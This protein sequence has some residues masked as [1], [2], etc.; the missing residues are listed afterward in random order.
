[1]KNKG[2]QTSKLHDTLNS[3]F[4]EEGSYNYVKKLEVYHNND[5]IFGLFPFYND[6]KLD[7]KVLESSFYN[8]FKANHEFTVM[9]SNV[10]KGSIT[11]H[12]SIE[13]K[14]GE[15]ITD[16]RGYYDEENKRI[17]SLKIVTNLSKYSLG[18]ISTLN[19][20]KNLFY[21]HKDDFFI[22]GFKTAYMTD[23]AQCYLSYIGVYYES[24]QNYQEKY[25]SKQQESKILKFIYAFNKKADKLIYSVSRFIFI[26]FLVFFPFIY[27]YSR[28]QNI[29]GG[30]VKI[31][32]PRDKD[33][34]LNNTQI[35]TDEYG[36]VHIK[37]ENMMDAMFSLGF[38]QS[39]DRLFQ[40]DFLR[41]VA[42]GRLSEMMGEG[43][44]KVDIMMRKMGLYKMTEM[45]D[46]FFQGTKAFKYVNKYVQGINYF[47]KNFKLPVEYAMMRHGFD[48]FTSFDVV[49][50]SNFMTFTLTEDWYA[51]IVYKY[52]E[53]SIGK[54]FADI[55]LSIK[56]FEV[57]FGDATIINDEELIDLGLSIKEKASAKFIDD[58]DE[59]TILELK[60]KNEEAKQTKE[61][62]EIK[63]QDK[64]NELIKEKQKDVKSDKTPEITKENKS[65]KTND[66]K[67]KEP[68][69]S[70]VPDINTNTT[71]TNSTN[72]NTEN[73]EVVNDTIKNKTK[74]NNTLSREIKEITKS[75]I[76]KVKESSIEL[77]KDIINRN[78]ENNI[79]SKVENSLNKD[80]SEKKPKE[81]KIKSKE[82]DL[83]S[84]KSS[85]TIGID[86]IPTN[87]GAS[88]NWVISGKHTKNG[89]AILA[90]DPHL[91]NS[92]PALSYAAKI[93]LPD[94]IISGVAMP[95][96][97]MFMS[98]ST[99][100]LSWGVT[101]ENNDIS[102]LCEEIIEDD[103]Y[104]FND[105][106]FPLVRTDETILIKG[107]EEENL[108]VLW[109]K[110]GPVIDELIAEINPLKMNYKSNSQ[111]SFRIAWYL[112]TDF[113]LDI[114]FSL[115]RAK[116]VKELQRS[117]SGT[118][119][120]FL[121]FVWANVKGDIGYF[122]LG[123]LPIK[124]PLSSNLT[125][126]SFCKGWKA[127]DDYKEILN[128][129]DHP[130]IINP[131]KGYM[132]TANNRMT[133][134]NYIHEYTG[135]HLFARA[136]RIKQMIEKIISNKDKE[137]AK[138]SV[139]DNI[140][141]LADVKDV[142][143]EFLVPKLI[144]IYERNKKKEYEEFRKH[145]SQMQEYQQIA[146]SNPDF[147]IPESK[148]IPPE[149]IVYLEHLR[150][151]NYTMEYDSHVAT[152]YTVLE[153]HIGIELLGGLDLIDAQGVLSHRVFWNFIYSLIEKI[154]DGKNIDLKA[155]SYLSGSKNCEKYLVKVM[156]K[157]GDYIVDEA[158]S[159]G[160]V[161][162]YGDL[163]PQV[164]P[165]LVFDKI[166]I[167]RNFFSKRQ[168]S[169]GNRNTVKVSVN[170]YNNP[171]GKFSSVHSP[172]SQF[173]VDM[174]TPN[175]PYINIMTGNSGNIFSKYYINRI[176]SIDKADLIVYRNYEFPEGAE[177]D[178]LHLIK[179]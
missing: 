10:I 12:I 5:G 7:K 20:T 28:S 107:R 82:T 75:T 72:S 43:A 120:P 116:H 78:T 164:Y 32:S 91:H 36:F 131:K 95:G 79:A 90:N 73:Q 174:K 153:Y 151:W 22:P 57:P 35:H 138:I 94:N 104:I 159:K 88:N 154:H 179:N 143:A 92:I 169:R 71:N 173:I 147:Q 155:C 117:L 23:K 70:I 171:A 25:F 165:S 52:L 119:A 136:H 4:S 26:L 144:A 105:K 168:S 123:K 2:V 163:A 84:I 170:R 58:L 55:V 167:L 8:D 66:N 37:A 83:N 115:M 19:N 68:E 161:P 122:R 11:N 137:K 61:E 156:D 178:T 87:N 114:C 106:K 166:P 34:L 81:K 111:F 97:P 49:A 69:S 172:V 110:N 89:Y 139:E 152:I 100:H 130:N 140:E 30:D 146:Q 145:V 62:D 17:L 16:I 149:S 175:E 160:S 1:M 113:S 31:T 96:I 108:E 45:K 128:E 40:I 112:T 3:K 133:S 50:I 85:D 121:N 65:V 101:S 67:I 109:T 103:Y 77:N 33:F 176:S 162:I 125:K 93:Y 80:N 21:I 14:Y 41:R 102:D 124:E 39:R 76:T 48:E 134:E 177:L 51:E 15:V 53:N 118:V 13:F 129:T 47:A 18:K 56:N 42:V 44:L 150:K 99:N 38:S 141:F 126:R 27:Y 6:S 54:E 135:T 74:N 148:Y 98:G 158:T 132:V 63:V 86:D 127:Q 9:S 157:L 64:I 24:S 60:R 29:Y 142:Y 59:K 46:Q